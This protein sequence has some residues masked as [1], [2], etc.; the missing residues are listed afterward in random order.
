MVLLLCFNIF[1]YSPKGFNTDRMQ[2]FIDGLGKGEIVTSEKDDELDSKL[3]GHGKEAM[4][5]SKW[6]T[7]TA[8]TVTKAPKLR[9][10]AHYISWHGWNFKK[11]L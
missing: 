3:E 6:P 8:A 10:G 7:E 4:E 2:F 5:T 9:I 1:I 11:I